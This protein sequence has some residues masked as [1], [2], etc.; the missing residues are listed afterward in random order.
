MIL[1]YYYHNIIHSLFLQ[2]TLKADMK[3][4]MLNKDLHKELEFLVEYKD[5]DKLTP[6]PIDF[7]VTPESLQNANEVKVV[8]C[9]L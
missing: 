5:K 3:R 9:K 8:Q 4:G 6:S 2:Y 7:S 1:Q